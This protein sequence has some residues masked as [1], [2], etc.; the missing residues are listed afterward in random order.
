MLLESVLQCP[1]SLTNVDLG[2]CSSGDPVHNIRS[3]LW[4]HRVFDSDQCLV[5]KVAVACTLFHRAETSCTDFP[6]KED[7]KKHVAQALHNNGYPRSLVAKNW[8][9]TK[10]T[11]RNPDQDTS[12]AFMTLP[13]I[14]H[15]SETIRR[16]LSPLEIRTCFRPHCTLRQTLVTVKVSRPPQQRPGVVFRI[17][18][19]TCP[20]VYIGP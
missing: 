6:K 13:Y 11:P 7:E 14:R 10:T 5:H 9:P 12:T 1:A 2:A 17:P 16:I 4:W 20:K 15:L 18:C 3:L 19:R 8:R